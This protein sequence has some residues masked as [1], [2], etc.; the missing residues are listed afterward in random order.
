MMSKMLMIATLV[1]AA[2]AQGPW[3]SDTEKCDDS[4]CVGNAV[5]S[6]D[7]CVRKGAV[8]T[9]C[10][11][12]GCYSKD[13]R[14]AMTGENWC[15]LG[16]AGMTLK[17]QKSV[18]FSTGDTGD[19]TTSGS[20]SSLPTTTATSSLISS[21]IVNG[22]GGWDDIPESTFFN[23]PSSLIGRR[24]MVPSAYIKPYWIVEFECV[25]GYSG[26]GKMCDAFVFLYRCPPCT[27]Q[28]GGNLAVDLLANGWTPYSCSVEFMLDKTVPTYH[29]KTMVYH[30]QVA[31]GA[32][33]DVMPTALL[34]LAWFASSPA[35]S[36]C[37]SY[38]N[39]NDCENQLPGECEWDDT[40]GTCDRV[41]CPLPVK[42]HPQG[43]WQPKCTVCIDDER[44]QY[45]PAL[46]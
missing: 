37:A 23:Y 36:H 22:M 40:H 32:Y 17:E 14:T 26:A 7:Q 18:V 1:A 12:P 25:K 35:T 28:D 24:A 3:V 27:Y 16:Y 44:A 4:V 19:I 30:K 21:T 33:E 6:G 46:K 10:T 5:R 38:L 20:G 45:M 15:L 13:Q 39:E 29:H 42:P 31:E 41:L 9:T 34:E 8:T 43:P 11:I 2:T